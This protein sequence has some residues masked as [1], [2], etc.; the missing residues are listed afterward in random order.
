MVALPA[1]MPA[2]SSGVAPAEYLSRLP[3]R[4]EPNRGQVQASEPVLWTARGPEAA[5]AFTADGALIRTRH[6]TFRMRFDG[7]DSKAAYRPAEAFAAPTSYFTAAYRGNVPVY[8]RLRRSGIYPGIDIVFYGAG[9]RLEYD[10]EVAP[11]AD[12]ARI[13]LKFD[14]SGPPRLNEAGDLV[15]GTG[16]APGRRS[17][18]DPGD[19]SMIQRAPKVYQVTADGRRKRVVGGYRIAADGTV[20]LALGAYDHTAALV[21]DPTIVYTMYLYGT[22]SDSAVAVTHDTNGYVY[23]TGNTVSTDFTI[24][25]TY[26]SY[27]TNSG[28]QD[29][30]VVQIDPLK[31]AGNFVRFFSYFGGSAD[32]TVKGIAADDFGNVYITGTTTSTNLPV[33]AGAYQATNGGLT[34]A[35]IAGFDTFH[36]QVGYTTYLGGTGVDEPRALALA[37]G[38]IYVTGMTVSANFPVAGH[39]IRSALVGGTKT[40][41]TE[42]DPSKSG[43]AGLIASTY[44]GGA[45]DDAGNAI[46]VDAA[47]LVYVAGVTGSPD[48]PVTSNAVQ[49]SN[50]LQG[51]GFLVKVNLEAG[52]LIYGTYLGGFDHDEIASIVVEPSGHVGVAGYTISSN[53]PTTQNAFQAALKGLAAAFLAIIDPAAQ[54]GA[55][56]IYSTYFGGSV[57]EI[58][59]S[60][61]RDSNG[62]Y[63]LGGYSLSADLP[64]GTENALNSASAG[65]GLNG[66][67]AILD[68]TKGINGLIYSSYVTGQGSQL[69]S[70]VDVDAS[71][72]VYATGWTTSDIFPAGPPPKATPP[73]DMDGFL[74]AFYPST[75]PAPA[76]GRRDRR[77]R[78]QR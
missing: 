27:L 74:L 25:S 53:F 58:A 33:S 35:F 7:S 67:V 41:I 56:L 54:P 52:Q 75:A 73:G 18:D 3:L 13:R 60:T 19:D 62:V 20:G 42:I 46:A 15:F 30:W 61:A 24:T 10:F 22:A 48:F 5:Y 69:V 43:S 47:G 17:N 14:G 2:A 32:E 65:G 71:G 51:D 63:V 36:A 57:A 29:A 66:F 38:H 39:P 23:V 21:I 4:F 34:D 55:G 9:T 6:R 8:G 70:G 59:S 28:G 31:R 50:A 68:P 12:P 44:L 16:D 76:E 26:H 40:F 64:A 1:V 45:G 72:I 78:R 49:S 37:N 11:G 77:P